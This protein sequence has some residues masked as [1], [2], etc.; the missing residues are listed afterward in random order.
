MKIIRRKFAFV[1]KPRA[2]KN[3]R[4]IQRESVRKCTTKSVFNK[5]EKKKWHE[6]IA[7]HL[8]DYFCDYSQRD[9]DGLHRN[10]YTVLISI[11]HQLMRLLTTKSQYNSKNVHFVER[12][13]KINFP[14]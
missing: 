7:E 13:P 1:C 3:K 11:V 14:K 12:I 8:C 6:L 9:V 5:K 10:L 4:D 2:N